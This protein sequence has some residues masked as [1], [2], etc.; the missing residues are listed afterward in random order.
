MTITGYVYP[1][2]IHQN[3]RH[4]VCRISAIDIQLRIFF[5]RGLD[6]S[7]PKYQCHLIKALTDDPLEQRS[8]QHLLVPASHTMNPSTI[9]SCERGLEN[10]YNHVYPVM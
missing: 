6:L 7:S 5:E 4:F 1:Y 2:S 3:M 8:I 9:P 10:T